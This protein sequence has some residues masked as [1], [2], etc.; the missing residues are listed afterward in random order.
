MLAVVLLLLDARRPRGYPPGPAWLPVVGTYPQL[1]RLLAEHG[2]MHEVFRALARRYGPVVGLRLGR[3][4]VVVV[5]GA[6]AV[7]AVLTHADFDGRPDGF[8]FRLRCFGQR[9]GIVFTEGAHWQEQRRFS[10]R[11]LKHFGLGRREMEARVAEEAAELVEALRARAGG[12]ARAVPMGRAFDVSVLNSLWAM[13]AGKRFPL[14]DARLAGLL[15]TLSD[16]FRRTDG[17]GGLLNQMP[18][19]RFVAP[20]RCGYTGTLRNLTTLWAFLRETIAEHEQ[21]MVPG[22][23]RDLIDAFL[24]EM[25]SKKGKEDST[26]TEKQLVSLLLDLFMAGAETTSNTLGFCVM[27]LLRHQDVQR[28]AQEELDRVVGRDREP[29]LQD[30]PQLRYLEAVLMEAQRLGNIAP[31]G[32]AHRAVRDSVVMGHLVPKDTI[33]LA[34]LMSVHMDREHWGDPDSFRPDRFL[35]A[36]GNV[37]STD[38]F[39]PFGIG[40]R[41]CLGETLAR[42]NLFLFLAYVL[43]HFTLSP[44]PEHPIGDPIAD[45]HFLDGFTLSPKPFYAVL[46]PRAHAAASPSSVPAD[47]DPD[48]HSAAA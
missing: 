10:L 13:L 29:G 15:H 43:H 6:A 45:R 39:L 37:K 18:F 23:P 33:V 35:D 30:R 26:Y 27:L 46:T 21:T 34:N 19:L 9:L 5:S 20:D 28:R 14:D 3:D 38:Y 11:L 7:R 17:S 41:R 12:R 47:A 31:V 36:E 1:R 2:Y 44:S 40:K 22:Q 8:F 4:R 25:Q 32:V 24:E 16:C 48:G 42:S